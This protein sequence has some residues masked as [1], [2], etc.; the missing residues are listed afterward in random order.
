LLL[1]IVGIGALA[2]LG[3][4]P[5]TSHIATGSIASTPQYCTE[6]QHRADKTK[7]QLAFGT[8]L[9]KNGP[10]VSVY[11]PESYWR[12]SSYADKSALAQS[13]SCAIAGVG[14]ALLFEFRSDMTGN[15]IGRWSGARL[16]VTN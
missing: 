11:I 14:M 9:L 5:P 1:A 10:G 4:P 16:T 8:G 15:I 13:I 7:V 6:A 2:R 3:G 12:R